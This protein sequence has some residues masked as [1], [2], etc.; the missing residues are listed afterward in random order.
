AG[1]VLLILGSALYALRWS[2]MP[3]YQETLDFLYRLEVERM[4]LKLERVAEALRVCG[5]PHLRFPTIHIAGTNGKGSTAAFLHS[6]LSAAGYKTGLFTSPHLVD[7]CERIRLGNRFITEQEVVEGV[8]WLRKQV[9]QTTIH[10]TP[11][12]MMTV[13]AFWAF[14]CAEVDVAVVE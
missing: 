11:F 13:L 10:L 4:D 14:A 9:E 8:S 1:V 2:P 12:E 7:F 5:S 3:S 6:I